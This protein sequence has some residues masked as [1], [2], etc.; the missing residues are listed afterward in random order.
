MTAKERALRWTNTWRLFSATD[1][2]GSRLLV[3]LE[4]VS[5]HYAVHGAPV[6]LADGHCATVLGEDQYLS[7]RSS[8][9]RW[10][11]TD[12]LYLDPMNGKPIHPVQKFLIDMFV[13]PIHYQQ[14]ALLHRQRVQRGDTE[15]AFLKEFNERMKQDKETKK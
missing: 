8:A 5:P 12:D 3:D 10:L 13:D 15:D 14:L 2:E 4:G 6:V 9:T 1:V 11:E 7:P